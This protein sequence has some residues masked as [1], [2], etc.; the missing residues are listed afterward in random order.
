MNRFK[1]LV[2][3]CILLAVAPVV[4]AQRT[5]TEQSTI[6]RLDVMTSK[7]ESMRRSL[8]SALSAMNASKNDKDAKPNADDP[9]CG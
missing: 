2:V 5:Q 3:F 6:Q 1:A 8:N 9:S 4:L 7:L